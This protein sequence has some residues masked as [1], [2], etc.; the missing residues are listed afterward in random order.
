MNISSRKFFAPIALVSLCFAASNAVADDMDD[1]RGFIERYAAL[2]GNLEEQA[3]MIRDDR[4]MFATGV[5]QR[6]NAQNMA[7]QMAQRDHASRVNGGPAEW[8]MRAED[9][10]IRIYGDVAVASFMRLTSIFPANASAIN[11]SPLWVTLVMVKERGNWGIAHT[12]ISG[13]GP[14]SN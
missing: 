12:H 14:N 6:T 13:V 2:E 4:V 11:A 1:V 3:E 5:R 8:M 10:E 7:A 9:A